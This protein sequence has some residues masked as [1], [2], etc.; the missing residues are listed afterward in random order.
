MGRTELF[1]LTGKVSLVT[2][3]EAVL[4]GVFS[5]STLAALVQQQRCKP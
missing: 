2:G 3:R 1:D 5:T 4:G